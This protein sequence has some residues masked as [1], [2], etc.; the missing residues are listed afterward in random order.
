MFVLHQNYTLRS[1]HALH[2][3]LPM[4]QPGDRFG[5]AVSFVDIDHDGRSEILVGSPGGSGSLFAL[6]VSSN[7]STVLQFV[8]LSA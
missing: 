5:A 7:V 8:E 6:V 3:S 2:G 4:V 1:A